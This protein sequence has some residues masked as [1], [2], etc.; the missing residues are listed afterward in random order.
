MAIQTTVVMNSFERFSWIS[1][2]SNNTKY[3][4]IYIYEYSSPPATPACLWFV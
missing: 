3:E 2:E 4:Y 1:K